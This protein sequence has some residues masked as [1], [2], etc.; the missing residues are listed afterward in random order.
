MIRDKPSRRKRPTKATGA[1][2]AAAS[3]LARRAK[4]GRR[5]QR[6]E[7][8][9]R[10]AAENRAALRAVRT[11]AYREQK[12]GKTTL[13]R[14]D[15]MTS[16]NFPILPTSRADALTTRRRPSRPSVGPAGT[17]GRSGRS[18]RRSG[19]PGQGRSTRAWYGAARRAEAASDSRS[20]RRF[21]RSV[22]PTPTVEN[23]VKQLYLEQQRLEAGALVQFGRLATSMGVVPGTVT[24]MVRTLADAGLVRYEP[25]NGVAL[26]SAGE[27]LALHVLRR[28]R[29][30]EVFLVRVLGLDW[31]EVHAE[32]EELEHVISDKVLERIDALLGR[33]SVDP[34]GDPIPDADGQVV[35]RALRPLS[36]CSAGDRVRIERV[37]NQDPA[38]L[39]MVNELGLMPASEHVV[40]RSDAV[41]GTIALRG[42]KSPIVV[43]TRAAEMIFVSD[44]SAAATG[45]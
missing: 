34:H 19:L 43:G 31:S 30:V 15:A 32:A 22:M 38:F 7:N 14:S 36:A 16:Q 26:T 39:R 29:L 45:R 33:P 28:H 27:K 37:N 8:D 20:N 41:A 13:I 24:T 1:S 12:K 17:C 23:Y 4:I 5:S 21:E 10:P 3:L 40:E 42:G 2:G 18:D 11:G 25:R 6:F 35:D 9:P 44:T